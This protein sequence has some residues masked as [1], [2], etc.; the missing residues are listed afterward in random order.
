M[1]NISKP[2]RQH[3]AWFTK[4]NNE[5]LNAWSVA[6]YLIGHLDSVEHSQHTWKTFIM[7]VILQLNICSCPVFTVDKHISVS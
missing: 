7:P 1:P 3:N 4:I 2:K 6:T 5:K